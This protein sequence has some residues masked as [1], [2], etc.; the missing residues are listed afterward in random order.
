[1]SRPMDHDPSVPFGFAQGSRYADTSPSSAWGGKDRRQA[2]HDLHALDLAAAEDAVGPDLEDQDHQHVGRKVL[3]AAADIGV[4]E[5]RRQALDD[6]DDQSAHQ[7]A[8]DPV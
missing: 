4:E 8:T 5:A 3:G 1:M 6:A 7:R 2:G